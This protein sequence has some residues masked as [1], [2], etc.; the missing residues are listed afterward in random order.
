MHVTFLVKGY[1]YENFALNTHK[2]LW[3][4][5]FGADYYVT[6]RLLSRRKD[7]GKIKR[8][9]SLSTA[10]TSKCLSGVMVK[11]IITRPEVV[12]LNSG[13]VKWAP[14]EWKVHCRYVMKSTRDILL[15]NEV[16]AIS[17]GESLSQEI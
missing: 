10:K 6:P 15:C 13:H 7:K 3:L 1:L 2:T 8:F 14:E 17:L 4:G 12:G 5:L 9:L 11:S 16:G